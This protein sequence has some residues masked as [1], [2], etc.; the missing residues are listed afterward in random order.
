MSVSREASISYPLGLNF[1]G[2]WVCYLC[3]RR[4]WE[5]SFCF[6]SPAPRLSLSLGIVSSVLILLLLSSMF[7]RFALHGLLNGEFA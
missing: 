4:A 3:K 2:V 7:R 6:N 1:I 5:T